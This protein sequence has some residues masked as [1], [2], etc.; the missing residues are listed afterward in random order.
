MNS[1]VFG[2]IRGSDYDSRVEEFGIPDSHARLNAVSFGF[3][4]GRNHAPIRAVVGRHHNRFA[5]KEGIGL[6]LDGGTK[7]ELR[8]TCMINGWLRFKGKAIRLFA[9]NLLILINYS[10]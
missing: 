9:N 2:R 6:L 8:S 10:A 4:R 7:Q 1:P 5:P 3:N